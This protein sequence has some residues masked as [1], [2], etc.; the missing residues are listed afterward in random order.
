MFKRIV[1]HPG[2]WRSVLFLSFMY[3]LI[4]LVVQW[5]M[6]GLSSN[7]ITLLLQ[8]NKVWMVPIAGFIAGFMVSYGKFWA[9]LKRQDQRK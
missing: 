3:L 1:T 4:L 5:F 6:T 7:F 9:R 8:S 2:F